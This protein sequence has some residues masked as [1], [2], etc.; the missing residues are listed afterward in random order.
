MIF[1]LKIITFLDFRYSKR[2]REYCPSQYGSFQ[3]LGHAAAACNN[4]GGCHGINDEHCDDDE[5]KLCST[6]FLKPADVGSC[7]YTKGMLS[8]FTPFV[9]CCVYNVIAT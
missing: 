8:L 4:D 9:S 3:T 1:G 5:Y 6:S 7:V 2:L